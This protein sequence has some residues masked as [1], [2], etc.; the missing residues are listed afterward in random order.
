[1]KKVKI[2]LTFK[3]SLSEMPP[4]NEY[5]IIKTGLGFRTCGFDKEEGMFFD[6]EQGSGWNVAKA[7]DGVWWAVL[8]IDFPE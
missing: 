4:E 8:D 3:N 6:S 7:E 2:E 5:L 1:M